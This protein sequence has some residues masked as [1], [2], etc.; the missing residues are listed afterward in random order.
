LKLETT[1]SCVNMPKRKKH[2]K[3]H[4]FSNGDISVK[5]IKEDFLICIEEEKKSLQS[6]MTELWCNVV[7]N[8]VNEAN[9]A[10]VELE[11]ITREMK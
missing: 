8:E 1:M 7:P 5:K 3:S 4:V 2:K 11:Q 6:L 9:E 10:I